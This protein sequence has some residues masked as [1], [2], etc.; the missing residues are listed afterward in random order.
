[1]SADDGTFAIV[2]LPPGTYRLETAEGFE[3]EAVVRTHLAAGESRFVEIALGLTSISM[4]ADV[5]P[6]FV[7]IDRHSPVMRTRIDGPFISRLPLDGRNLPDLVLLAPGTSTGD[8]AVAT[9]G[10]RDPFTSFYIDNL[11]DT[12]PRLGTP[13]A[14]VPLDS[15]EALDV[16][17]AT[18]DASHG[19][20]AGA[21]VLAIT[22][23]GTN[24]FAGSG[25]ALFRTDPARP[26]LGAFAGGPL[27][28]DRTFLF[29]GY[30]FTDDNGSALDPDG[31]HLLS[32]RA[33]H[34]LDDSARVSGRY[35][36]DEGRPF[37][38]RGQIG[39]ASLLTPVRGGLTNE[40]HVGLTRVAFG[41]FAD[42][43]P[44]AE[45]ATYRVADIGTWSRAAHLVSAGVEWFG[46]QHGI[47]SGELAATTWGAFVHDN[48]RAL[49]SISIDAG[50]RFD[51]ASPDDAEAVDAVSPRL[52]AAWTID[53]DGRTV[54]RG[55]Y[56]VYRNIA[57][58]APVTPRVDGWSVSLQRR[59]G[60]TRLVE[61]AYVGNRSDDLAG[62]FGRSHY[63]A[64]QLELEQRNEI[65]V[66]ALF[67]YTYGKWTEEFTFAD[68][69]LRSPLNSRHRLT[70]A[71]VV[72]LP[73]GD[74]RRWFDDGIAATILGNLELT[75]IYAFHSGRPTLFDRQG[76]ARHS[77]DLGLLKN[78]E[79]G[80]RTL[81]LRAETFNLTDRAYLERGRR[82]Q[83]G[84]RVLF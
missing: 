70:A 40:L 59:I 34:I 39:G 58:V 4:E 22:K 36:L 20:S 9:N 53:P 33:D 49:P 66:T 23:S 64:L 13:A 1:M 45:S 2:S 71:F 25:L 81:Q 35:A 37:D 42:V 8:T 41:N 78:V 31:N 32:I 60:R 55:G 62:S 61:A 30:Q 16:R 18:F 72:A 79:I 11:Y 21:R 46:I 52:G 68:S 10:L 83:F 15:M 57:A 24:R 48:W 82:Y 6:M 75:G 54:V 51:H 73:F 67:G 19:R 77:I 56:G 3:P 27:A 26:Q 47:D 17:T 69:D 43:V 74:E 29:G 76:P 63:N 7:P 80:G 14:S 50:L 12:E 28:V 38:R 65:G 44:V 84:G 5:R